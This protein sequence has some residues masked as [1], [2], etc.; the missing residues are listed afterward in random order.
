MTGRYSNLDS[1]FCKPHKYENV[2]FQKK[3]YDGAISS[4]NEA[5]TGVNSTNSWKGIMEMKKDSMESL[6]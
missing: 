1:L 3:D 4:S 5:L 2:L 6:R